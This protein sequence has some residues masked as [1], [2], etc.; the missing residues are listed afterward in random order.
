[1]CAAVSTRRFN[2]IAMCKVG[3]CSEHAHV[4]CQ[5]AFGLFDW[6]TPGGAAALMFWLLVLSLAPLV[7]SGRLPVVTSLAPSEPA[8]D[9]ET[10]GALRIV[11][12]VLERR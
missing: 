8:G 1:M 2:L 5:V 4:V 6:L 10:G 9:V 3:R 11:N 7:R 12:G